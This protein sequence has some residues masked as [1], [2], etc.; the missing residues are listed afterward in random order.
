MI[1]IVF[2]SRQYR[3]QRK[4]WV[5]PARTK[6][7]WTNLISGKTL[8][9]KWCLNIRMNCHTF[10][11]L[12]NS[13]RESVSPKGNSFRSDT[14]SAEKRVAMVLYYL[15]DQGSYR[16]TANTFGVSL[17]TMSLSLRRVCHGLRYVLG[18]ELI[19]FPVTEEEVTRASNLFEEKLNFPQVIGVVDGTHI[20]IKR[21]SENSQDF[22]CYKMKYSLN[23]MAICDHNGSFI[24][25]EIM[26]PGSVHDARVFANSSVK[27]GLA[28][29]SIANIHQELVPGLTPVP[30]L[31]IG[32]PAYQL[33]PNCMNEYTLT[34]H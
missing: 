28:D 32:D 27:K 4:S 23:V 12:V 22:F 18:P 30:A 11:A 7:W 13:I 2:R 33:L 5:N 25:V 1:Q 20:P 16:M 6:E 3:N 8:E 9:E 26:C 10:M 24:D 19:K 17:A 14:I 29:G 21:P 15:K 34:L 31:L